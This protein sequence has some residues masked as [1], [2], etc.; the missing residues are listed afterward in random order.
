LFTIDRGE[1]T[2]KL[3]TRLAKIIG[4]RGK[5]G[6]EERKELY[7]R[8]KNIYEE[9]GNIVHGTKLI[10]P[11]NNDVLKDT[12]FFARR[13]L[14]CILLDIKLMSLYSATGGNAI[15]DYFLDLDLQCEKEI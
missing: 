3:T 11:E 12:F 6:K 10:D 8:A 1:T 9:R 15:R 14:Q 5:D 4:R 13:G 7:K 2:H